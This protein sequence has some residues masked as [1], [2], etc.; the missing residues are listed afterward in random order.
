MWPKKVASLPNG[1]ESAE[2]LAKWRKLPDEYEDLCERVSVEGSVSS[3][4]KVFAIHPELDGRMQL[5]IRLQG[6]VRDFA[7]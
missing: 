2:T 6:I 4:V 5:A 7:A 1:F 3:T